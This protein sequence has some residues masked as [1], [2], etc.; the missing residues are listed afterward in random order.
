M[1]GRAGRRRGSVNRRILKAIS[2]GH[3]VKRD[4]PP[5]SLRP[6]FDI[7]SLDSLRCVL[8]TERGAAQ[9]AADARRQRRAEAQ[10]WNQPPDQERAWVSAKSAAVLLDVSP[11]TVKQ[12]VRADRLPYTRTSGRLWFRFDHMLLAAV[13][14]RAR[15]SI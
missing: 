5:G 9:Q 10:A 7:E 13:A 11:A 15:S 8:E 3:L 1:L 14:R 4:E 6:C 2:D 12:M